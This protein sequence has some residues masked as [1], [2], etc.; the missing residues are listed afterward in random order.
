MLFEFALLYLG[1]AR[2]PDP[3]RDLAGPV[4]RRTA[5]APRRAGWPARRSGS[6]AG[7]L[8]VQVLEEEGDD[9]IA[10]LGRIFNQ[11]TRQLKGQREALLDNHRADRAAAAAVR[12]G[13]VLG[14]LGRR[15]GWTPR[16]ASTS[17]TARPSGCWRW[18]RAV[19]EAAA[20]ADAVP[21]FARAAS[22]G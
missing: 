9:E 2:D 19:A 16:G 10:M 18:T 21:E 6:G 8:D 15:S 5:V 17:S 3:G 7:D 12:F 13:A 4:V 11:M 22:R 14:H 20:L 1:F